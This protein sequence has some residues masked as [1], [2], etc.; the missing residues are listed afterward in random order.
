MSFLDEGG[1][2]NYLVAE[3]YTY[4]QDYLENDLSDVKFLLMSKY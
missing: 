4:D 2:G 3:D 1:S